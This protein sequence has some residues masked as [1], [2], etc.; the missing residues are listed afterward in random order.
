VSIVA[1]SLVYVKHGKKQRNQPSL[2]FIK[3]KDTIFEGYKL[4]KE[5]NVRTLEVK[6]FSPIELLL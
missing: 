6:P 3:A 5:E 1:A 2:F 4:E